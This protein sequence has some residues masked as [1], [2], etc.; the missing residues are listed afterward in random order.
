MKC[1]GIIDGKSSVGWGPGAYK[2]MS[3]VHF[4]FL[5]CLGHG[6]ESAEIRRDKGES[7]EAPG[8]VRIKYRESLGLTGAMVTTWCNL[9]SV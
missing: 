7:P 5:Y 6:A 3:S 9:G 4:T 2:Y 1:S 8:Q